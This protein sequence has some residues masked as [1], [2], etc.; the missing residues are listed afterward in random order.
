MSFKRPES[1][2]VVI[3]T[4]AGQVLLLQRLDDPAFWQS[5]TGTLE[6]DEHPHQTALREVLEETG[7]DCQASGL[8]LH[9]CRSVSQY[10]IRSQWLHRYPPGTVTNTEYLFT[11]CVPRPFEP[12]LTEHSDYVWLG[13][14]EARQRCWSDTN[15]RAIEHWVPSIPQP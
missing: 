4:T 8:A 12:V 6:A 2:L 3:H 14:D 15:A 5:V 9:D 11:L 7:L 10:T 13:K 1:V